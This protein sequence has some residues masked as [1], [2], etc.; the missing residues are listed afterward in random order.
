MEHLWVAGHH[1]LHTRPPD[2]VKQSK[3]YLCSCPP[4]IFFEGGLDLARDLD[5]VY[6]YL[7]IFQGETAIKILVIGVCAYKSLLSK[8]VD[9]YIDSFLKSA[10][11]PQLVSPACNATYRNFKQMADLWCIAS[12]SS[13][14]LL[15]AGLWRV[16]AKACYRAALCLSC[17]S[18]PLLRDRGPFVLER[19]RA[20]LIVLILLPVSHRN[21]YQQSLTFL[22]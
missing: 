19:Q 1:F 14:H 16:A 15:A 6:I 22:Q 10:I 17:C 5:A 9:L 20:W 21:S 7:E 18:L 8:E 11:L 4:P 13:R 12:T 2:R 3:K